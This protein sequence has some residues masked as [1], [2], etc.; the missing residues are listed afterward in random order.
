V[1]AADFAAFA[2]FAVCLVLRD[3]YE[4]QKLKGR[5]D[6]TSTPV[7][8]LVFTAMCVMWVSWFAMG[9]VAPAHL[10]FAPLVRWA[11]LSAVLLGIVIAVGG[12]WQLRGVEN[13]D[14]LVMTGLFSMVRHPM[15]LG[16]ALWIIGWCA[17][18]GAV[19]NLAL[20]PFGLASVLWWRQLEE[21]ALTTRYG[22][23][24]AEYKAATWF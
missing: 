7:F 14:H 13:I 11:G 17:Y 3:V 2:L 5:V 22:S 16:F 4:L 15:Y 1:G 12:V 18:T 21:S 24:Y 23:E 8:A 6:T 9:M 10:P 19:T 20:A